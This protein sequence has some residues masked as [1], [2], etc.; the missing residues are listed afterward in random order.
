MKFKKLVINRLIIMIFLLISTSVLHAAIPTA[1]GLFRN[2]QNQDLNGNFVILSFI[3]EELPNQDLLKNNK[4]SDEDNETIRNTVQEK[5]AAPKYVRLIFSLENEYRLDLLQL[6]YRDSS[7]KNDG[8]VRSIYIPGL[9][10]RVQEDSSLEN[11][12]IYSILMMFAL[13]DSRGIISLIKKHEPNFKQND[14][15]MNDEKLWL[16]NEYKKYLQTIREDEELK[17]DLISPLQ[18]TDEEVKGKV[19]KIM[20]SNLYK[21]SENVKLVRHEG[22]FYWQ[23]ALEKMTA[24]FSNEAHRLKELALNTPT[25]SIIINCGNYILFDGVHELPKIILYKNAQERTFRIK[26]VALKNFTNSGKKLFERAKD[27]KDQEEKQNAR[28]D[29]QLHDS[30]SIPFLY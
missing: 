10:K 20:N 19:N 17:K 23:V 28:S 13:N 12:F 21:K 22:A 1:E 18:P 8:L 29:E 14:E 24:L 2:G 25:G 3:V 7:F 9:L 5:R 4:V 6:E 16:L 30:Y 11:P 15:I 26:T 27:Y